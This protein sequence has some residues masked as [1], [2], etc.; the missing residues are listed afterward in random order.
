MF[1]Q[2]ISGCQ[3]FTAHQ[4]DRSPCIEGAVRTFVCKMFYMRCSD[5]GN[6]LHS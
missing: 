3:G 1:L 6:A 2:A 4:G 5:Y